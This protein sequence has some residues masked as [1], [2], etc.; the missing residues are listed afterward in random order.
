MFNQL[1]QVATD[2]LIRDILRSNG[3]ELSP[4]FL[5]VTW[6]YFNQNSNSKY[7][8][9]TRWLSTNQKLATFWTTSVYFLG[10]TQINSYIASYNV[11]N[12]CRYTEQQLLATFRLESIKCLT[13]RPPATLPIND[14]YYS[15]RVCLYIPYYLEQ[16][17]ISNCSTL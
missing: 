11:R 4:H 8:L 13:T 6:Q 14:E 9:E 2:T 12:I 16:T 10:S 15:N 17:H 5:A 7:Y 3:F 1:Y